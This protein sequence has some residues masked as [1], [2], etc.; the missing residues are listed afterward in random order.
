MARF[1]SAQHLYDWQR[2]GR[3]PAIHDGIYNL[4]RSEISPTDGPVVDL[5]SSTGLLTR[6]LEQ[7][8]YTVCGVEADAKA[9]D[10]GQRAGVY[11]RGAPVWHF[12]LAPQTLP[13]FAVWVEGRRTRAVVARRV[14][15][16]LDNVGVAPAILGRTLAEAGVRHLFIE[17]RAPRRDATHRLR[18]LADEIGELEEHWRPATF[19]GAHRAYLTVKE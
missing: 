2:S 16:E 19:D 14:L 1:D 6:R 17:G 4:V 5:G 7:V 15:P 13:E 12:A 9:V 11:G 18:R 8:G 3:F 10:A